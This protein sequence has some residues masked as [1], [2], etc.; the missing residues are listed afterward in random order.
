[1]LNYIECQRCGFVLKSASHN[2]PEPENWDACPGC[3]G[4]HFRFAVTEPSI[5]NDGV[6][7]ELR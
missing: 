5:L 1:M 4:G 3:D 7:A 2:S 6:P